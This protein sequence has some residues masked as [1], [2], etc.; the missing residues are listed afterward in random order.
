MYYSHAEYPVALKETTFAD[1]LSRCSRAKVKLNAK[2][3]HY[4]KHAL[5]CEDT[6]VLEVGSGLESGTPLV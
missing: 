6:C 3:L 1:I 5:Y 2:K 4:L